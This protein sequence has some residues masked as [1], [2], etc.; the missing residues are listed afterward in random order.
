MVLSNDLYRGKEILQVL[1]SLHDEVGLPNPV[2][3]FKF[4]KM[5]RVSQN[6]QRGRL[7]KVRVGLK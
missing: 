3:Y 1:Q 5:F 2:K 7:S 6:P 4:P